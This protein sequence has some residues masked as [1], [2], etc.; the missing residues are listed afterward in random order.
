MRG[1]EE[2]N[3]VVPDDGVS[4]ERVKQK[5]RHHTAKNKVHYP[6]PNQGHAGP[7]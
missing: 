4:I 6:N 1:I 2:D 5:E 7:V 3:K